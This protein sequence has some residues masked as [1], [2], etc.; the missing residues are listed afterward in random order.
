[1]A[2]SS[3]VR[4]N[5]AARPPGAD[6]HRRLLLLSKSHQ[7]ADYLRDAIRQDR[8]VEPLPGMRRWS[9]QLGVSR[10]TLEGALTE[11][12]SDGWLTVGP[13]GIRLK[14]MPAAATAARPPASRRVRWLLENSYRRHL[15]NYHVTFGLLQE[16]LS[17]RGIELSWETCAPARLREIARQPA[18]ANELFLLA[19][20]PPA[21]Q[22][23][24]AATGKPT[25]ILGEVTPG[26]DL[27]F[28]NADLAGIVRHA[29]FRLLRQGCTHLE[30]IH[31]NTAAAG[32]RSAE[33]AFESACAGWTRAP[34]TRRILT[35]ALDQP[36]LFATMRRLV[37][38]VKG[39]TGILVLAPVPVGLVT[40]AL[41]Q[42]GLAVP[43]QASVVALMH[44]A[45]S[46]QLLPPPVHYPWPMTA[47]VRHISTVT[48]RFFTT[49]TLPP[50][51]RTV[52]IE[53]ARG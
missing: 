39:R 36:S 32:L 17:L 3:A 5:P 35:S 41:L 43:A 1:M 8:L 25:L 48:E 51:G 23:L 10:R 20:L 28:I 15:Y 22:R 40:T 16:R 14:A 37:G 45:E 33:A 49:G 21:C 53:A 30:M 50:G 6:A 19:S 38:G 31:I 2:R 47:L 13:R 27:P 44:P 7:L 42:A 24:F 4:K 11:L 26:L 34:V 18:A 46:I 29:T 9:Q 12:R 52:T